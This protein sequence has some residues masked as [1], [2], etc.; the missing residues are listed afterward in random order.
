MIKNIYV[1][2]KNIHYS[3]VEGV[4]Y[5]KEKTELIKYPEGR[6]DSQFIMPSVLKKSDHTRLHGMI[7]S[8]TLSYQ[9]QLKLLKHLLLL[10]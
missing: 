3:S 10:V 4:L 2:S 9:L 7:S 6:E 1:D 8:K 5:N